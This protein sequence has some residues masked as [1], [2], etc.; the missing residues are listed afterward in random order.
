MLEKHMRVNG[1]YVNGTTLTNHYNKYY[2]RYTATITTTTAVDATAITAFAAIT[3]Y[4]SIHV[5]VVYKEQFNNNGWMQYMYVF[6]ECRTE[7]PILPV[8]KWNII[9]CII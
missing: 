2:H 1:V 3:E 4:A 5:Y 9:W 7:I 8:Q 6:H